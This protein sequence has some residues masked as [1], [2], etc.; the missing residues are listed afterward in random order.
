MTTPTFLQVDLFSLGSVMYELL[1]HQM[2]FETQRTP[3][4]MSKGIKPPLPS[5]VRHQCWAER[6]GAQ[7]FRWGYLEA[8]L[9][10]FMVAVEA[11]V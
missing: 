8:V 4:L 2:P 5:K 10:V 7:L 6:H 1:S 9:C 11:I 3:E